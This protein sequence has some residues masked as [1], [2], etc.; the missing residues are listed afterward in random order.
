MPRSAERLGTDY[1]ILEVL[2]GGMSEVFICKLRS[3][4]APDDGIA[5]I[6]LKSFRKQFFFDN[7]VRQAF[8]AESSIWLRLSGLL[9][10]MPVIGIQE[11]DDRPFIVMP[12]VM[13]G[14]Q[15]ERTLADLLH[16][17]LLPTLDALRFAFKIAL[18]LNAAASRIPGVAHGDL[19]PANVL[20]LSG[21]PHIA[22]FG[23]AS[24]SAHW[25]ADSRLEGSWPYR[26]PELWT[27]PPAP[28][29]P[30]TD[31]Y[32]FGAMLF[33][34][35]TGKPPFAD[36]GH[37]RVCWAG[38]HRERSVEPPANYPTDAVA[39]SA[40]QVAMTCMHKPADQRLR[41]FGDVLQLL[42]VLYDQHHLE[43]E[44]LD[45]MMNSAHQ[46]MG[47]E[48]VS[49]QSR[50]QRIRGLLQVND[51][52]PALE[53]LDR[54]DAKE[55]TG[56]LWVLR[57]RTLSLLDRDEE[58]LQ[59]FDRAEPLMPPDER[60][61][62]R[63][64]YA[65]SLKRL[66]RFDEAIDI[67][68]ALIRIA[69][70]D[71]RN[72]VIVNL[73]S[74]YLQQ[75]NGAEVVR[76]LRP[77]VREKPGVGA[78]WANL[79]QALSMVGEYK[80]AEL[81]YAR[82]VKL[83][84]SDGRV[85]VMQAALL[86]DHLGHLEEA[87]VALDAAFDS[88]HESR[89]WLRRML[90]C[91]ILL[92]RKETVNGLL[93]ALRNNF[94]KR[95]GEQILGETQKLIAEL[96]ERHR[97]KDDPIVADAPAPTQQCESSQPP[98]TPAT[99]PL[100]NLR[101]NPGRQ[102]Y[103][104]DFYHY[105]EDPA[106][107]TVFTDELRRLQNDPRS[108][109]A[110]KLRGSPFYFT[111]C[112]SCEA[113]LLT[114]CDVDKMIGCRLCNRPLQTTATTGGRLDE[115]LAEVH[116]LTGVAAATEPLHHVLFVQVATPEDAATVSSV[117]TESGVT[118]LPKMHLVAIQMHRSAIE[119]GGRIELPWEA[120]FMTVERPGEWAS[121]ATPPEISNVLAKLRAAQV[122][123]VL[124]LSH[125]FTAQQMQAMD[126]SLTDLQASMQVELRQQIRDGQADAE[127]YRMLAVIAINTGESAEAVQNARFCVAL[128][129]QSPDA[130]EVLGHALIKVNDFGEARAALERS[131][132]LRPNSPMTY[133]ALA[134]CCQ[135]LGDVLQ[136]KEY[137]SRA[138]ALGGNDPSALV[139]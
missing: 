93:H 99:R 131:A 75:R 64:E 17:G 27:Q 74:T 18:G 1:E 63:S 46:K 20:L 71:E 72:G 119:R 127:T 70:G 15:G 9:H 2:T 123:V 102:D 39:H 67:Y 6:A 59:A 103:T 125:T 112:P 48:S 69:R 126:T 38:A 116:Q 129:E 53:E 87:F 37:D 58:A 109:V 5:G 108:T 86:M 40:M 77:F 105:P 24:A 8:V 55:Y 80:E 7:A 94:E 33:E 65:L 31:I 128:D 110:G 101:T 115:L 30:R 34:M 134:A 21:E 45:V 132:A 26:A 92:D 52:A 89:E 121:D 137:A 13:P 136:A 28:M 49:R 114:N 22:D 88:G 100:L 78:A 16:R 122:R 51:L 84:P 42:K 43:V 11:I 14:P 54:I 29:S 139:T 68:N 98:S 81:A 57:G 130:W 95:L 118:P 12:A 35:L 44:L 50:A 91:S 36:C 97:P 10:I 62:F 47:V 4:S 135:Q 106:F 96:V 19:K 60:I 113:Y 85:R 23:L 76:L 83:L 41:D 73:A 32:A 66:S 138:R 82:A 107:L 133:M 90:A 117:C 56:E 124:S 3:R 111:R 61:A 104:I 79:G 25:R 120:F